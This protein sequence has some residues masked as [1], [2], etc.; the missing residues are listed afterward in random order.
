MEVFKQIIK[1]KVVNVF[2]DLGRTASHYYIKYDTVEVFNEVIRN[3]GSI[4]NDTDIFSMVSKAQEFEQLKV[5][6]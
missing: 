1:C 6:L 3:D 4:M 5:R 2:I